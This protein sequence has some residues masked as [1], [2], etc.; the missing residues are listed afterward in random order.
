MVQVACTTLQMQPPTWQST[1]MLSMRSM[2]CMV[3]HRMRPTTTQ[4]YTRMPSRE[5]LKTMRVSLLF[6]L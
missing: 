3:P 4:Q 1:Q 5:H 2:P 6:L